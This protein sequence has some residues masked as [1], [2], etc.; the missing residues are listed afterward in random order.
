MGSEYAVSYTHLDVYKRQ[1]QADIGSIFGWGFAP[2]HGGAIS[3]I[4]NIGIQKFVAAC[5]ALA[6]KYGERF[7]PNALLR[8]MRCV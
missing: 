4:D 6:D 1:V 2:Y 5:D 8:D 3:M 7:R